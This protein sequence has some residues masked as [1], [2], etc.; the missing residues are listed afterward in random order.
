MSAPVASGGPARG[1]AAANSRLGARTR[2]RAGGPE[3]LSGSRQAAVNTDYTFFCY[4]ER[5]VWVARTPSLRHSDG[6]TRT[7]LIASGIVDFVSTAKTNILLRVLVI[8]YWPSRY[9][10]LF[11]V[12]HHV[13]P[14]QVP[15]V[16][17]Y[18][19]PS[20]VPPSNTAN[21]SDFRTIINTRNI[22]SILASLLSTGTFTSSAWALSHGTFASST[23][24]HGTFASSTNSHGT[25]AS[26]TKSYGTFASSKISPL[27][28]F[29]Q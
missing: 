15:P 4:H 14:F 10:P 2:T 29:L 17:D 28:E 22:C 19:E 18:A 6:D 13:E 3:P 7:I 9:A 23:N 20:Q 16:H 24:S 27:K 1:R 5:Q 21:L 8:W 11:Q 26:S 12:S 25:F